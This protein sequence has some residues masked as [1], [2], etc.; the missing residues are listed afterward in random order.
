MLD[1]RHFFCDLDGTLLDG[2][3]RVPAGTVAFMTRLVQYGGWATYCTARGIEASHRAVGEIPFGLPAGYYNGALIAHPVTGEVLAEHPVPG[4]LSACLLS[5]LRRSGLRPQL[6]GRSGR[7]QILQLEPPGNPAE[8]RFYRDHAG[9]HAGLRVE[10]TYRADLDVVYTLSCIDRTSLLD[11]TAAEIDV[12]LSGDAQVDV[13]RATEAPGYSVLHIRGVGVSKGAAVL[14]IV[15]LTGADLRK[16]VVFGDN[17]NDLPMFAVAPT[18]YA[19]GN[20]NDAAKAS[21][22]ETIGTNEDS[23]VARKIAEIVGWPWP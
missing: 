7:D 5:E 8:Q 15:G 1:R 17:D 19:V 12:Y 9:W 10:A 23:G 2:N 13:F 20:A 11:A 3:G 16:V 14:E 6:I 21:A 4:D 18:A 22:N